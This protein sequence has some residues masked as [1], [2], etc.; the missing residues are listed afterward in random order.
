MRE[1]CETFFP[2]VRWDGF[3]DA[4]EEV[5]VQGAKGG[6]DWKERE[7]VSGDVKR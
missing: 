3:E 5:D 2:L 6:G 7:E 1:L 4:A